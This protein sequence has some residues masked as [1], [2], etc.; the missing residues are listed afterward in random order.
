MS[1]PPIHSTACPDWAERIVQRRSLIPAPIFADEADAALNVFKSLRI[2]DAPGKPTFGEACEEWVFDFVRAIFGAYDASSGRR[3]I[4]EFFLLISKKN[5]K[6]TIAAGVML[7][8]LVRNWR[9]SAELLI[10]APTKE[11]ADNSFEPAKDMVG[12]DAE[13]RSLL[14]VQEHLRTITHRT[15]GATLQVIA[16][17][18]ET[19]GGTKAAFVLIDELWLFGKRANARNML[20][21]AT[22]GLASRPE[23]FVIA[24]STQSDEPPAGV[25][26]DWLRRFRAIRDGKRNAPRSLGVLY[27]FPEGMV[28]SG[29]FKRPENFYV[30]NPNLGRSVDEEFLLDELTKAEGE[31]QKSLVG[32]F[33]KHL[34]VEPG[35]GARSDNWA[36]SEVWKKRAEKVTLDDLIDRCEV[37]V[38]GLDGGGLDDLYGMTVVGREPREIEVA[39]EAPP[40]Q[41]VV[42]GEPVAPPPT[43]VRVKRWL[44][45]SHAWAHRIV[46]IRRK[47]I[48]PQ[49]LGFE[50]DGDLTI[51]DDD[52]MDESGYP[53]DI[54][55]I[56]ANIV[57]IRDA[58]LLCCVA[59]DPA[60]LGELVDALAEVG[61][62]AENRDAG[63]NYIVGVPQGYALMNAIK[64]SERKL[65]N[66]SLTHAD[67]PLMDWCVGNLKIEPTATAIRATKLNAGDAKIDPA[68]ALFNAAT[69]MSANPEARRSVYEERGLLVF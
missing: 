30:T 9:H 42:D 26:L 29:V 48:E 69:I 58:G 55:Q 3:L 27:E 43:R 67:Q 14:H 41:Y 8:A 40:Q 59:V 44:S 13:L 12:E 16:A 38:V 18:S 46:L 5:S 37:I 68:M 15:T 1:E 21:E 22:G 31:G 36:G 39:I 28:K 17:D 49:L 35:M 53:A 45:W 33:A 32:F 63:S 7:T 47:S 62:V 25:F 4:N 6:S 66:G 65:A 23:G 60:G 24:L 56:V 19:V 34:N 64:T 2:V 20:R 61:I 10:L 50:T 11:I 52:A 57:R 54:A 51:V